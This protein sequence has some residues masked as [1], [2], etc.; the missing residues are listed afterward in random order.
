ML[1]RSMPRLLAA[2]AIAL[3]VLA[4]VAG[5]GSSKPTHTSSSTPPANADATA[6]AHLNAALAQAPVKFGEAAIAPKAQAQADVKAFV[7]GL[8]SASLNAN[9]NIKAAVGV[10]VTAVQ[11]A[12][13]DFESG[14]ASINQVKTELTTA[15]GRITTACKGA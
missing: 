8:E 4:G 2:P 10:F 14:K 7:S 5:C 3:L 1:T 11:K 9:A 12:F 15:A 6:C 13:V